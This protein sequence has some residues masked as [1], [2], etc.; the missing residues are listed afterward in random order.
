[1]IGHFDIRP[2]E[3]GEA[4]AQPDARQLIVIEAKMGSG[5]SRGVK[6]APDYGQASRNVACMAH[7][8]EVAGARPEQFDSLAFYVVAPQSQIEAGAFRDLV[9]HDGIRSQVAA[10]VDQ[11]DGRHGEWF[12]E[13]FLPTLEWM[14]LGLIS[15]EELVDFI[16]GEERQGELTEFYSGCLKFNPLR[17]RK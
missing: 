14:E 9:T 7:A 2:G 11:Y 12:E 15:W 17:A 16:D 3:R 6:N 10:R 5:L 8:L 13:R 4:T 1:M